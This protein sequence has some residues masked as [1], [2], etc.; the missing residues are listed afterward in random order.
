MENAT[1]GRMRG[2]TIVK[3]IVYGTVAR[4]LSEKRE[5]G[6]THSW[7]LFL[8][9]LEGEDM[10]YIHQ[11]E[12][13]LHDSYHTPTRIVTKPPYQ[14]SETGWGEFEAGVKVIFIDQ[15]E[16][17]VQFYH[18]IKLFGE[19]PDKVPVIYQTYDEFVFI[20]PSRTLHRGITS[21]KLTD[22]KGY[23][24]EKMDV[25]A[26]EK[27]NLVRL[28]IANSCI[29]SQIKEI[30]KKLKMTQRGISALKDKLEFIES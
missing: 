27:E 2:V 20:D 6:H 26:I 30:S 11:V 18:P 24:L 1:H 5:D 13:R 12:F 8:Q 16:R 9:S 17:P 15:N 19:D 3:P 29:A 14:V 21:T 22:N 10:P 7:T 25:A 4:L 23:P 28:E